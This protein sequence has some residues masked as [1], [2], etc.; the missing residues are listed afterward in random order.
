M[1]NFPLVSLYL[2]PALVS[3]HSV[4]EDIDIVLFVRIFS[5]RTDLKEASKG[6]NRKCILLL[7]KLSFRNV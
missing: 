4:S 3:E 6:G 5:F 7:F 2:I 1:K